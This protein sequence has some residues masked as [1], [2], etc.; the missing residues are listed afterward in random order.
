MN[1][2]LLEYEAEPHC[3]VIGADNASA[4][5]AS[6]WRSQTLPMLVWRRELGAE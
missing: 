5:T 3:P 4:R 1:I 2:V 6:G